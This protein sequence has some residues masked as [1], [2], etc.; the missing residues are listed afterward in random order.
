MDVSELNGGANFIARNGYKRSD[1]YD[2]CITDT[3]KGVNFDDHEI[4]S[5]VYE[6]LQ[7]IEVFGIH[8][9]SIKVF[10]QERRV[11]IKICYKRLSYEDS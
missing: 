9:H 5:R 2:Y 6:V 1:D 3:I 7:D 8:V 4:L 11:K 10:K